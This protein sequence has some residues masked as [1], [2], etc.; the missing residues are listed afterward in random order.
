[1]SEFGDAFKAARKAGKTTFEFKGKKYGTRLANE[2]K[3][4][5]VAKMNKQGSLSRDIMQKTGK[6]TGY[7]GEMKPVKSATRKKESKVELP[8]KKK[9]SVIGASKAA[10]KKAAESKPRG[11][12]IP[13]SK[14]D[15]DFMSKLKEE[16]TAKQAAKDKASKSKPAISMGKKP[17]LTITAD[18]RKDYLDKRKKGG[19]K[20]SAQDYERYKAMKGYE[21]DRK[22]V[23]GIA[24]K[25]KDVLS[26][27]AKIRFSKGGKMKY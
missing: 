3:E 25:Y 10:P 21:S 9:P 19:R 27:A 4:Q 7:R 16:N 8:A 13:K 2:T 6:D 18:Q 1:M 17:K 14:R 26:R 24:D 20:A 15:D 5:H 12:A 23:K 11:S 22:E